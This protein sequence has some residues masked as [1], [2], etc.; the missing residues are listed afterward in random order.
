MNPRRLYGRVRQA[1]M[2]L[3]SR[4]DMHDRGKQTL[5]THAR[6]LL[7]AHA[8]RLHPFDLSLSVRSARTYV[9]RTPQR[10]TSTHYLRRTPQQCR[11]LW[12]Q[13]A[14]ISL[15]PFL[16]WLLSCQYNGNL[17]TTSSAPFLLSSIHER[18]TF[19]PVHATAH[20]GVRRVCID[21]VPLARAQWST[22]CI[23]L[24]ISRGASVRRPA[25]AAVT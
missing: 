11:A 18:R 8:S 1:A 19:G 23:S 2:R 14:H 7:L 24:S 25:W 3:Q 9:P 16:V 12:P 20:G 5:R 15:S 17:S 21:E 22:S 6:T 13:C 4:D 10:Q